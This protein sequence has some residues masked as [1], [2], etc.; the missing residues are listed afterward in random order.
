MKNQMITKLLN[1]AVFVT[2][3]AAMAQTASASIVPMPD[4]GT[5]TGLLGI[6]VCGLVA[7]RRFF[8]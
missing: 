3:V 8:R 5:T 7:M 4:A 6:A 2:V 1:G